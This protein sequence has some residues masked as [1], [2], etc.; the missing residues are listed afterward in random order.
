MFESKNKR[1]T[2]DLNTTREDK[3]PLTFEK[4]L[5]F[6]VTKLNHTTEMVFQ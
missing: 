1:P 2:H 5:F 4:S 3:P 6:M